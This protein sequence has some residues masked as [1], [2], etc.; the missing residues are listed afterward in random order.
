MQTLE[1]ITTVETPDVMG[2]ETLGVSQLWMSMLMRSLPQMY[3]LVK[4]DP[5][6]RTPSSE[7]LGSLQL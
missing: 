5:Q 1:G 3:L 7:K 2:V 6:K 4:V